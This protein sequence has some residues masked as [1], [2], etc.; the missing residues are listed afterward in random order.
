MFDVFPDVFMV[1]KQILHFTSLLLSLIKYCQ[2][3]LLVGGILLMTQM[4]MLFYI[5][6]FNNSQA[7]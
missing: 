3:S 6:H 4:S 5:I 7:Q 1:L 2:S